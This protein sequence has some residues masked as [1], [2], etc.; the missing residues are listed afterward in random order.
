M[1]ANFKAKQ[2]KIYQFYSV[3]ELQS[4]V[5]YKLNALRQIVYNT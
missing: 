4:A 5:T 1:Q 3:R 2:K